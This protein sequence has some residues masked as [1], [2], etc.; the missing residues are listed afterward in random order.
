MEFYPTHD[1][2][3]FA[4]CLFYVYIAFVFQTFVKI[5]IGWFTFA[6]YAICAVAFSLAVFHKKQW[7]FTI[8]ALTTIPCLIVELWGLMEHLEDYKG[9]TLFFLAF[10][11]FINFAFV[12]YIMYLAV[13]RYVYLRNHP[14]NLRETQQN[15]D[16]YMF[17][18]EKTNDKE[19]DDMNPSPKTYFTGAGVEIGGNAN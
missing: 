16:G 3:N 18:D 8:L 1:N 9:S 11:T 10:F 13:A 17:R 6:M 14:G 2:Q 19:L 5:W 12:L 7:C 4:V 15:N